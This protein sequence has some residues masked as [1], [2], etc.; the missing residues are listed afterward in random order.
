MIRL[1][2]ISLAMVALLAGSM[3]LSGG[4]A[5]KPAEFPFVNRGD[6]FTLDINHMSQLQDF[7]IMYATREGLYANAPV[8]YEAIPAGA[9]GYDLSPDK[10]VWTFHLRP[11]CRWTNGQPVTA[12]D[13]VFSW[14]RMLEEPGDYTYLF[15]YLQNAEDYE[16]SYPAAI[17]SISKPSAWKR[18]TP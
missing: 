12:D 15:H 6:V 1:F 8:T 2:V 10:R 11:G 3:M 5:R 7:R 13:Y 17:R 18:S 16:N 14:R 4:A 9:L